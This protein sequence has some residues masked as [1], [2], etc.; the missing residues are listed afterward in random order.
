MP[1]A[2]GYPDNYRESNDPYQRRSRHQSVDQL[3]IRFRI[4]KIESLRCK[5]RDELESLRQDYSNVVND[6]YQDME[7]V[8]AGDDLTTD[9]IDTRAEKAAAMYEVQ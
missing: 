1:D 8:V 2:G 9:Q 3:I 7:C 5:M 6:H 4:E